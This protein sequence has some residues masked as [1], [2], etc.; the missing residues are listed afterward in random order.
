MTMHIDDVAFHRGAGDDE[1]PRYSDR[2][3]ILETVEKAPFWARDRLLVKYD[4]A[5]REIL[6]AKGRQAARTECNTRLRSAVDGL[7]KSSLPGQK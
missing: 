4:S 3:F 6:E 2:G 1:E 5:Y 7:N